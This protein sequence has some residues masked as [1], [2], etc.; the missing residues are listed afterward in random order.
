MAKTTASKH[1]ANGFFDVSKAFSDFRVPGFDVDAIVD[2]QRKN[3]EALTQANQL[4]AEGVRA[5]AQRQVE[6]VQ[7]AFEQA[8]AL[9]TQW[10]QPGAP[11]VRLAKHAEVAKQAF[12]TGLAHAH[13]L[14]EL[15][16]K[17]NSDALNVITRRVSEGLDEV[18][19]FAKKQVAAE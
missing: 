19:L 15:A 7:Q 12:E 13:E 3:L 11:E 5:L 9:F 10:T 2:A 17:A 16:T 8:S 18:R 4:A 14:T 1:E 6:I